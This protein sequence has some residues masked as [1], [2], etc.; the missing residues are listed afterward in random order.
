VTWV[1][2][3]FLIA[4]LL[5]MAEEYF[6]PGGFMDFMKR[7]NPKFAPFVT[8]RMAIIINGL[9]LLLCMVAIPMGAKFP[10][11]GL[12]VAALLLLN[13][14][15]HI[16]GC[17][18]VKGYVPGVATGVLLYMPISIYAYYL[19]IST[20]RIGMGEVALTGL[21]GVLYQAVPVA[22]LGIAGINAAKLR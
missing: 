2:F 8:V 18:R 6:Y 12:S 19:F 13:A 10:V 21:L 4:S 9:Q 20:G 1:L 17:I 14:L 16:G 22:Y 11:F 5:H 15:V 7:L 3:A